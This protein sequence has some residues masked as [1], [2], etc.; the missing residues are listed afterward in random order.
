MTYISKSENRSAFRIGWTEL[1]S[2]VCSA[3]KQ[4]E[5][6]EARRQIGNAI[7][8]RQIRVRWADAKRSEVIRGMTPLVDE[9]PRE[10]RYWWECE[11]N[12]DC[13][14]EPSLYDPEMVDDD[15]KKELD[16]RG[17]FRTPIFERE[18]VERI[19]PVTGTDTEG[20][21]AALTPGSNSAVEFPLKRKV[22]RPSVRDT[23]Y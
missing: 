4:C 11:T 3:E 2:H 8:D 15:R 18:D 23:V 1:L 10:A 9:P 19:W 6:S 21:E 5:E 12:L 20:G 7:Q 14:L 17:R 13:V 22:G 16:K